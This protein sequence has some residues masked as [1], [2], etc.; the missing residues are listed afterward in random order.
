MF[1]VQGLHNYAT[2][3]AAAAAADVLTSGDD[4]KIFR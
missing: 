4:T 3:A 2:P 1:L